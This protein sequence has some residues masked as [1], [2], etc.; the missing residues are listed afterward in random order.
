[1]GLRRTFLDLATKKV[2]LLGH[3]FVDTCSK[4][5]RERD[6]L[7][8]YISGS[9]GLCSYQELDQGRA[10]FESCS[11]GA[12]NARAKIYSSTSAISSFR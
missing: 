9:T 12:D 5:S 6:V 4:L 3:D 2:A 7:H 11:E 10:L 1:M 8:K